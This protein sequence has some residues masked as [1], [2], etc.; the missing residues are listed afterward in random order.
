MSFYNPYMKGPDIGGGMSD[1]VGQILQILMMKKMFPAGS[2]P[3]YSPVSRNIPQPGAT[4]GG[5]SYLDPAMLQQI[6]M[7]LSGGMQ[8]I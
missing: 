7:M 4:M 3:S 8:R 2:M 1:I 5:Q 6:M